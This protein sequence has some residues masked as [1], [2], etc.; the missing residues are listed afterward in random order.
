MGTAQ[1]GLKYGVA[2]RDGQASPAAVRA[3]LERAVAAGID[4]LDTAVAYGTSE[5]V[6]GDAGVTSWRV[7]SKLPKLPPGTTDVAEW[8]ERQVR[9]S[10]ARLR[11]PHL[12]ALLLHHPADLQGA[13]SSDYLRVL[14]SLKARGYVR[15]TGVSIYHPSELEQLW[16][17]WRPDIVQ[18]PC[19]VLDR[20]LIQSGWLARLYEAGIRVHARSIFMQGLLLMG[21]DRPAW[22][23]RWRGILDRWLEWCGDSGTTPL[24]AAL[25][26]VI[27]QGEIERCVIGVDSPTQLDEVL[28][29][30][31]T[32]TPM[33][34][35]EL[36]SDDRDLL[37][38]SR[39]K[40]S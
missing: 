8:A 33:L 29:A 27:A 10:L 4:T 25:G 5:A 15:A 39:W 40:L 17:L 32:P 9:E 26:F 20:R 23:E 1:F 37:D 11:V 13:C 16:P 34:P 18:A 3:I 6:L 22:F 24:H 28:V 7:V 35:A 12:D 36:V 21:Q 31:G 14:D 38:P 30:A 2:N 19:N